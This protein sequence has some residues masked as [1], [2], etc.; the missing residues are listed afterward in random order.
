M[1]GRDFAL[2]GI[3]VVIGVTLALLASLT[4]IDLLGAASP[5]AAR[6]THYLVPVETAGSWVVEQ[7]EAETDE[8]SAALD[9]V[10]TLLSADDFRQALVD[11]ESSIELVLSTTYSAVTGDEAGPV[12]PTPNPD[13]LASACLGLDD[14]PYEPDGPG[15]YVYITLPADE[16]ADLPTDWILDEPKGND[17]YW[18]LLACF[19]EADTT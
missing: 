13:V 14:N 17:L 12:S 10:T 18:Q 19:P 1:K 4:G 6:P 8:F 9:D 3:G 7:T 5:A 11:E 15:L 16:A 2:I